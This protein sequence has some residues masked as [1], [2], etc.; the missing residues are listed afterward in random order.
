MIKTYNEEE[1]EQYSQYIQ[2][3]GFQY[4]NYGTFRLIYARKNVVIKVPR[5]MDGMIDNY[6][7]AK[8]YRKYRDNKTNIGMLL[9]PCRLLPNGCLMMPKVE[10]GKVPYDLEVPYKYIAD[11]LQ[12]A[13]YKGKVRVYDFA[14]DI[15]DRLSWENEAG[16]SSSWFAIT[17]S[18]HESRKHLRGEL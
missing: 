17:Y 18:Q 10:C 2:S 14:I 4:I 16:V 8:A 9:M 15:S 6:I 7:E 5:S 1:Y 11:G 3:K 13:I 12:H